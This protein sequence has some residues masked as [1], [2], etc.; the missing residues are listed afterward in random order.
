V[1]ATLDR[2]T[3][4]PV[5]DTTGIR[6]GSAPSL[7][8]VIDRL[9]NRPTAASTHEAGH[10]CISVLL[11]IRIDKAVVYDAERGTIERTVGQRMARTDAAQVVNQMTV[12]AAGPAAEAMV[13]Y[14]NWKLAPSLASHGDAGSITAGLAL[15]AH[16]FPHH[17]PPRDVYVSACSLLIQPGVT[18]AVM[19]VAKLLAFMGTVTEGTV[20]A[21][22]RERVWQ[23]DPDHAD[24][25]L[26]NV[27]R[28]A[29]HD[30]PDD[31]QGVFMPSI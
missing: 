7:R 4:M 8:A 5:I 9:P 20:A 13:W 15:L 1:Y 26:A 21:I 14:T 11:G 27:L 2:P 17:T 12:A 3:Y 31:A 30:A 29:R 24:A 18:A 16:E 28:E 23:Y 25:R 10:A 6:Q 22:V 19:D